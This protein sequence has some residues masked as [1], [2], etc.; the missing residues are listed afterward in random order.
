MEPIK[1]IYKKI[2]RDVAPAKDV[3]TEMTEEEPRSVE[4][5]KRRLAKK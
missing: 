3:L 1:R 4:E 2:F 5:M